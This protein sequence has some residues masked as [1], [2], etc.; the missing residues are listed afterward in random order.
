MPQSASIGSQVLEDRRIQSRVTFL[1]TF[2][3]VLLCGP[4]P[5]S[6]VGS[7]RL[8]TMQFLLGRHLNTF[9]PMDV[10]DN[11]TWNGFGMGSSGLMGSSLAFSLETPLRRNRACL[12]ACCSCCNRSSSF[13]LLSSIF[14]ICSSC[15]RRRV[16]GCDCSII[17]CNSFTRSLAG[18]PSVSSGC[19]SSVGLHPRRPVHLDSRVQAGTELLSLPSPLPKE[20][21]RQRRVR[22][23]WC[24]FL[25][26][27]P[28][29]SPSVPPKRHNPLRAFSSTWRLSFSPVA[30]FE[31]YKSLTFCP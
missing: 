29:L 31:R 21:P 23:H 10:S 15:L 26:R 4:E 3:Q 30:G 18:E 16:P 1:N 20:H 6:R 5:F 7:T 17:F 19:V 13:L 8:V 28:V 9:V 11:W 27:L 22:L 25:I 14:S 24:W 12:L 2:F